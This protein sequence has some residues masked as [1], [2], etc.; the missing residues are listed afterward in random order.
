MR[1][2]ILIALELAKPPTPTT[3]HLPLSAHEYES[4][5]KVCGSV[6]V[7]VVMFKPTPAAPEL[8]HELQASTIAGAPVEHR[9]HPS[10]HCFPIVCN[11]IIC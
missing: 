3:S 1:A 10:R 6:A 8:F 7:V 2:L 11:F 4:T 5:V 9:S